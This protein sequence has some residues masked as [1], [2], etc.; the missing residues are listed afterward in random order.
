MNNIFN[1]TIKQ[2]FQNFWNSSTIWTENGPRRIQDEY[3]WQMEKM[4]AFLNENLTSR[5]L[6]FIIGI[7]P[8][9]EPIDGGFD[10]LSSKEWYEQKMAPFNLSVRNLLNKM[11]WFDKFVFA[12]PLVLW[13]TNAPIIKTDQPFDYSSPPSKGFVFNS[14]YYDALRMSISLRSVSNGAYLSN[15]DHIRKTA[16]HLKRPPF[17]SEF[18]MFIK[19]GRVKNQVRMIEATYQGME[20]SKKRNSNF[21]SFYS[22]SIP[23]TQWHWDI[24]NNTHREPLNGNSHHIITKG[25]AWNDENFSIVTKKGK[26]YTTPDPYGVERAWPRRCQGRIMHFYYKGMPFDGRKEKI[27]WVALKF[28]SSNKVFL[29]NH[30][31]FFMVWKGHHSFAPTEIYLPPH[32]KMKRM[33]LITEEFIKK[34]SG[35]VSNKLQTIFSINDVNEKLKKTGKRILIWNKNKSKEAFHFFLAIKENKKPITLS[36][37]KDLKNNIKKMIQKRKSPLTFLG[38]VKTD[39]VHIG[40][41][42]K[43]VTY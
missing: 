30:R 26:S 11:G 20:I 19:N 9:N 2:A 8:M 29:E 5:E 17:L 16:A 14:H 34:G 12:E 21:A 35:R 28:D 41:R 42:R 3:L 31:F 13:N 23:G 22:P 7:N 38:T 25:D 18:G 40:K 32:F 27:N 6:Q 1:R 37:L 43:R 33:T 36:V 10:G 39:K 15:M 24:Y 4:M